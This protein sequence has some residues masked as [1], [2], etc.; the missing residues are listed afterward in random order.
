MRH[1]RPPP[2]PCNPCSIS[3]RRRRTQSVDWE[4]AGPHP[5]DDAALVS[6]PVI[7]AASSLLGHHLSA[8]LAS[9]ATSGSLNA[10]P[11]QAALQLART[12]SVSKE[13]YEVRTWAAGERVHSMAL[14]VTRLLGL[15]SAARRALASLFATKAALDVHLQGMFAPNAACSPARPMS[16]PSQPAARRT[17]TLPLPQA[18]ADAVMAHATV[19][20]LQS[21]L[22]KVRGLPAVWALVLAAWRGRA[23]R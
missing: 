8:G 3:Q 14:P 13:L 1:P 21:A 19:Q 11:T 20:S 22:R 2:P 4:H 23:G 9:A 12:H 16:P 17:G 6:T 10:S 7:S 18:Q 15:G 5:G